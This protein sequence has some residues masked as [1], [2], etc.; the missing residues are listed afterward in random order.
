MS[1]LIRLHGLGSALR[2]KTHLA[3]SSFRSSST[4]D[5]K[6]TDIKEVP[7]DS[8]L[9]K[10]ESDAADQA[11]KSGSVPA[12]ADVVVIGGG[13][14]GCSTAYHLAKMGV[15]NVVLLEKHKL[16]AG[17][18]WHTAGL[19]WHLTSHDLE[20]ELIKHT[21]E[22]MTEVLP[23]ETGLETG[24]VHT[25]GLFTAYTQQR[26][27][28][29]KEMTTLA[30]VFDIEAHLLSP[31]EIKEVHPLVDISNLVGAAYSPQDGT[32]D[33]A[34][35]CVTYTRAAAKYGAKIL[36]NCD[37]TS[38]E[39]STDDYGIKR[40][41]SI[42]TNY[43]P[44][45]TKNIVNC[46]GVWA[47][48][49]GEMVGLNVPQLTYKHAYVV[50]EPIEGVNKVPNLRDH[51]S[52]IY[53][54]RQGDT[55]QIGGYESNPIHCEHVDKDF[56]FG[57]YDLDW[58]VFSR[59]IENAFISV[60][61]IEQSGIRSTVCG[62]ESFTADSKPLLGESPE[63]RGFFYGSGFN[64]GGMMYG[65]GA[66]RELANWVIYGKPSIDMFAWD[67]RRFPGMLLSNKS[68]LHQK[69]HEM[70]SKHYSIAFHH[71]QPLAGRNA[72]KDSLHQTLADRGCFFEEKHGWERPGYFMFEENGK[73]I[74]SHLLPYD[75]YGNYDNVKH[76]NY[77]YDE[78]L[79][80]DYTFD[81]PGDVH[82]QLA[83]ESLTCRTSAAM[84]NTSY[85]GKLFL[86]GPDAA[87]AARYLFSRD[88]S[89]PGKLRPCTYTLM[90]ND[91]GGIESDLVVAKVPGL[92]GETEFYMTVGG[93]T[94]EY[95]KGHLSDRLSDLGIKC[96]VDDRTND[97]GI[98]SLQGPKSRE[99]LD[100]LVQGGNIKKLKFSRWMSAEIAGCPVLIMRISFVGE[101]GYELH[102]DM[103]HMPK[104]YEAIMQDSDKHGICDSGYRAMESLS[105]E[106]GFHHWGHS[107]RYDDNPL[108]ARLMNLCDEGADYVGSDAINRLRGT[109]PNKILCCFTVDEP[110]QLFG[111]E[112]IWRNDEIVGYTR[113]AVH[114]FALNK[115]VAFGYV[116]ARKVGS[117]DDE[118]VLSGNYEVERMG[119]RYPAQ[120]F[121]SSPYLPTFNRMMG[122]Y[123]D[124]DQQRLLAR[125]NA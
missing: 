62:P 118:A 92:T 84:F 39:T 24:W 113:N 35:T 63:V 13:S 103:Q 70:Y 7:Y 3:V 19:L 100:A 31:S 71:D 55:L 10:T 101:L 104:I 15:K 56:A 102:C 81:F 117:S 54:K 49:V 99:I 85:M 44:I 94:T 20:M 88:V 124:E 64:S 33:P 66:G 5:D 125:M 86:T 60:P 89:A 17:T 78:L 30:K 2:R 1:S 34:G 111:H 97:M 8:S 123:S 47:P 105:T 38:I 46:T 42:N 28:A 80:K 6:I 43:G 87:T 77:K 82:K 61:E 32:M 65:G 91:E 114:G 90:L 119:K 75:Y 74:K 68:W 11:R 29:Y 79:R 76:D 58:D 121:A 110:V 36:E 98:L 12:E 22:L 72:R 4:Y 27:D 16:T 69:T 9:H 122:K 53:L 50:T 93:A 57:L 83:R 73:P 14:V 109:N 116:N 25:G 45:K 67:I 41:A 37:V 18:T 21:R 52:S 107:I 115:E 48:Y 106:V 51:D 26:F 59:H 120:V 23:E 108:E 112:A 96:N 95:C 40:I